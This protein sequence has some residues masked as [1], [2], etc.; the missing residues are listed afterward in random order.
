MRRVIRWLIVIALG[1]VLLPYALTPLYSLGH[2]VS[3]LM[4]A[5]F[6]SGEKVTRSW[7][8]LDAMAPA[9]PRTVVA[10]ED[11]RFCFHHGVD[12]DA[13]RDVIE[14]AGDGE[15]ARGG[16][17]ITQQ[18]A[19]NL[20]LWPG[21]SFVRKALE[22]PLALWIDLVLPK[23]RI[24]ELYLN[25]AELGPSGQFGAEAGARHA[26]NRP[27]SA[28]SAQEAALLAASLPN[29]V[30]RNARRPG[31]GLRRLAG[32]YVVRAQSAE[33]SDCWARNR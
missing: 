30:T 18:V 11:A 6:L 27:A 5:R 17:T 9:L 22:F 2:P 33:I 23:K 12:W 7:V 31:P 15:L 14:D 1:L 20:F 10:A 29:P 24:L 19:K 25:V 8:D 13:V 32:T 16:S 4:I 3:T 21:R 28:L 26:F